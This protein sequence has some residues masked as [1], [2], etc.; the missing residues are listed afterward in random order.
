ML[1]LLSYSIR[2]LLKSPG[3]T[4]T[5]IVIL[6]FSIGLSTAI[7]SLID[8]VILKPLPCPNSDRL[9]QICEP[10]HTHP[11]SVFDYPDY[12]DMAAAQHTFDALAL[13]VER[14]VDLRTNSQAQLLEAG[15]VSPSL[16]RLTGLPV[17]LGRVFTEE[18][19]IP[20][21]PLVA[22][23]SERCWRSLF[24]SDPNIVG[25]NVILSDLNVQ[26]IG[27]APLQMDDWGPPGIDVY[28]PIH[29]VAAFHLMT[30]NVFAARDNHLFACFGRLKAGVSV[31][32]GE[33]DLKTIQSNLMIHYP[34]VN[35]GRSLQVFPLLGLV[36][37]DY[38]A[39][40]WVLAAAVGVLLIVSCLN[41]ANLLFARG[42][43]RRR[44]I[45][46]RATLGA[47]RWRLVR[48]LLL[49]T[50]LLALVGGIAGI[51]IAIVFVRGTK[52]LIP[53]D[54]YRLQ[55]LQ[56]NW[57]ALGFTFVAIIISA[58]IAGLLPALSLSQVTLAQALQVEG[59]RAGTGGPYR[60]RIQTGLIT[61]QV[62]LSCIL[63]LA[64]GLLIRS[65]YAT[66]TVELGFKPDHLLKARITLTSV[67]YESDD[68]KIVGFWD[69][70]LTKIRQITGVTDAA[71]IED[72]P[73]NG[74]RWNISPFTVDGQ[75]KP[76][77][78]QEPVVIP[79]PVSSGYFRT[80]QIPVI[81]GRDF[82]AE[83]TADKPN[84]VIVNARLAEHFFP[85]QD[86]IGKSIRIRYTG[87]KPC[88]IVGIVPYVFDRTPGEQEIPF[89]AYQ[90][91]AQCTSGF[92]RRAPSSQD[93]IIR[94]DIST[95]T[96]L[97]AVKQAVT[98]IDPGVPIYD[99]YAYDHMIAEQFVTRRLSTLLVA[100]FSGATL[101]LS[102]VGL[103]G[104]LS[105]FVGQ[106]SRE[107]G[108]RMA[109]GAQTAN[110]MRL[111]AEQGLRPVTVGLT[112]GILA[113]PLLTRFI[114]ALLYRVSA[115]DPITLLLTVLVL[116]I[117][118]VIACLLP[119]AQAIRVNP[120][121]V[122]SE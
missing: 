49:E 119:G 8:A 57:N 104:V 39:T 112:I 95:S 76:E 109:L 103:Y 28:L 72:P 118:T 73:L 43:Y 88:T 19:D 105:Y 38:A 44:E 108:I 23:L 107:I 18:E 64:A 100:L 111:V 70:L 63:L 87:E 22:V 7:F 79:N 55:E 40:I 93:V 69:E 42:L 78:G 98:S 101:F 34:N 116:G 91:Y 15:F 4:V 54:L 25:R 86:P 122:L 74:E 52:S 75:P 6:G 90:P 48:Q 61:A 53:T 59:G 20:N 114:Q 35:R 71:V 106:K 26:V 120:A 60:H 113:G 36:V 13:R 47:S 41:I 81:E 33:A 16:F 96:L 11:F 56:V 115:Y 89:Q 77:P 62:A 67:K 68:T 80:M 58:L 31:S 30:N 24:Q 99:A 92:N 17:I 3:V 66:Q 97:A 94:S 51:V 14:T 2:Q 50:L 37:S 121:K 12:I 46:I 5:A 117:A 32:E 110:I 82:N 10:Y 65:F 102:A 83:D 1:S 45:M 29:A 85:G 27:V 21:G 9:V 84:V